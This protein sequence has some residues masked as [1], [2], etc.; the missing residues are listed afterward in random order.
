[1]D[2]KLPYIV[3]HYGRHDPRDRGGGVE[4]FARRLQTVFDEVRFMTPS[5]RD[6]AEVVEN[7]L[8]VICD[9]HLVLDW[10]DGYPVMGFQHGVAAVKVKATGSRTD[11]KL[12]RL[13]AKAAKRPDTLWVACAEWISTTFGELY[14]NSAPHIVYHAVDLDRFDG[15]LRNAGSRLILHDGRFPHKGRDLYPVLEKAFPSWRFEPLDCRPEDV[16]DRMR[17]GA[18]FMHLSTYEGNSIVCNE[19]MAMNMACLFTRVGLMLDERHDFD[20]ELIDVRQAYGREPELVQRVGR[21]LEGLSTTS[22]RPRDWCV[23][24]ASPAANRARWAD[25]LT[26]WS[27]MMERAVSRGQF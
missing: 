25:A 19:A 16:P 23:E 8:P 14:G 27:A 18:A 10:P 2:G 4:A 15:R 21:F 5:S 6:I 13:Q 20:V 1:M 11:R 22:H 3:I 24:H 17:R 26:D 9:N 7:R 12:A